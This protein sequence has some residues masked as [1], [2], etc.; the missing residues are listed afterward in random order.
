ML[1]ALWSHT[2][3]NNLVT[4]RSGEDNVIM[5]PAGLCCTNELRV[6]TTSLE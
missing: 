1:Q 6:V 2:K 5:N 3:T 4:N